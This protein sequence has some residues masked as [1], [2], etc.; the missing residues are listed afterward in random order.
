MKKKYLM[1]FLYLTNEN[2]KNINSWDLG[3]FRGTD[4]EF[5]WYMAENHI[6]LQMQ[7]TFQLEICMTSSSEK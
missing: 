3:V 4:S 5:Y 6:E 1:I 7:H 2:S